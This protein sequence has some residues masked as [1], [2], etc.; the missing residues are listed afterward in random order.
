MGIFDGCL[1][2]CDIDGTLMINGYINPRNV[3][4]IEYFMSEGGKFSISTGRSVCAISDVLNQVKRISPSIVANGCMIYDYSEQKILYENVLPESDHK[5]IEKIINSGINVGI[6]IHCGSDA[7]TANR[8]ELVTEH[9]V[10]E[11]FEAPDVNY[12]D[13]IENKWHK[14]ICILDSAEDRARLKEKMLKEESS[15]DFIETCATIGGE[16]RNY[17]ELVP[18]GV[19]KASALTELCKL[20]NIKKGG[21]FA[22]GDYYNDAAML[23]LADI[24]AVPCDS[25]EDIKDLAQHITCKCEDGAVADFIDYLTNF[26]VKG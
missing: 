4:K 5:L 12:L 26:F 21:L 1:L 17:F 22:A 10:Y 6:E 2:A 13:I 8:T 20:M 3:E 24:S 11:K 14:V 23:K 25:P 19:S 9:Q 15:C 18:K 16:C 7:Y